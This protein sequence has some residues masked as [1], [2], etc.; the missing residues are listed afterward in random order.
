MYILTYG[1][2]ISLL[3]SPSPDVDV[4][5]FDSFILITSKGKC[6]YLAE[7]F[8]SDQIKALVEPTREDILKVQ[9]VTGSTSD[10][11][12]YLLE[13]RLKLRVV[14]FNLGR[15][16]QLNTV[17]GSEAILV[18]ACQIKYSDRKGWS[19][20]TPLSQCTLNAAQWLAEQKADLIGLQEV[21]LPY[22]PDLV[23]QIGKEYTSV[24]YGPVQLVYNKRKLGEG[25]L[26]SPL[27][28]YMVETV[29]VFTVTWFPQVKLLV[30]NL[31]AP[32]RVN[33]KETI[34]EAFSK[35]PTVGIRP[36]RILA[37][38]DFNDGYFSLLESLTIMGKI[39]RQHGPPSQAC[40]ADSNFRT[41]GDYIFDSEYER[42]GFYGIPPSAKQNLMSDHYPVA[43]FEA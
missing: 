31:H 15:N 21:A 35:V 26:I 41:V 28:L 6:T 40:C 25:Y 20:H 5:Q 39:L 7:P 8:I 42:E 19:E 4:Y 16:V 18:Q 13:T 1:Q 34:S 29:R 3:V 30:I 12:L 11:E 22:F 14:T 27:D 37:L 17:S 36:E 32:H 10:L 33:L 43:F 24:G 38:G 9:S 2:K 23:K